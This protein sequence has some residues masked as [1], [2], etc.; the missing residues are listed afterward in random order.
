MTYETLLAI[1]GVGIASSVAVETVA[2]NGYQSGVRF[3]IALLASL[4][5]GGLYGLRGLEQAGPELVNTAVFAFTA[6]QTWHHLVAKHTAIGQ[7]ERFINERFHGVK[8][9]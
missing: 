5:A 6:S 2:P 7:I 4:G 1:L 8:G 3:A 9:A